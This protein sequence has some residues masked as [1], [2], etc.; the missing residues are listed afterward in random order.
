MDEL[1]ARAQQLQ[2]IWT[3]YYTYNVLC[4]IVCKIKGRKSL[5]EI[6]HIRHFFVLI[7][8]AILPVHFFIAVKKILRTEHVPEKM[9]LV[10]SW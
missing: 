7:E 4:L 5:S 3:F 9:S 6:F 8:K 10:K 2:P 1:L